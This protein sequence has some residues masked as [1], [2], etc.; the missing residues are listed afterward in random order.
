MHIK[1]IKAISLGLICTLSLVGCTAN[2]S[3]KEEES[4]TTKEVTVEKGN[5]REEISLSGA[6]EANKVITVNSSE[7][8][9][10]DEIYVASNEEVSEGEDIV[11]LE[12]GN[13]IEA[14]FDGKISKIHISEGDTVDTS[15]NVFNIVDDSSFKIET[16]IDES[17]ITKVALGQEVEII[18]SALDKEYKGKV[19]SIDGEASTSGNSTTFGV[20]IVLEG[21]TKG[22]YT[23]MSSEMN[24]VIKESKDVLVLPIQS[25][26]N[27][28]GKYMVT[29]K[30]GEE[31]KEVEVTTGAQDSSFVE[32][33]TGLKVGDIVVY[34]QVKQ[35]NNKSG[36]MPGEG[37]RP[38]DSDMQKM[39]KMMGSGKKPQN[40]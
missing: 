10:I 8:S 22:L 14:P 5:I 23:G 19:S 21:E 32:I 15:S 31:T 20:E 38:S 27:Q 35:S 37:Q 1:K 2:A 11:L 30:N 33:K 6:I 3:T 34:E 26:K 13:V 40:N 39:K 25:V 7:K 28:K 18:V 36:M 24:I 4:N 12:N 29:V 16:S 17:E 9:T